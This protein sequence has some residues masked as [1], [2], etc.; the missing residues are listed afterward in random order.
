M[1][2]K[3]AFLLCLFSATCLYARDFV[4]LFSRADWDSVST[5]NKIKVRDE[6]KKCTT[7][8]IPIRL[9][10]TL[11]EAGT[12]NEWGFALC[13]N[14]AWVLNMKEKLTQAKIDK[15]KNWTNK[16]ESFVGWTTNFPALLVSKGLEYKPTEDEMP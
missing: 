3:L 7:A 15:I 2:L 16:H 4:F 6:L 14:G 1:K 12:T 13:S 8:P 10:W 5:A 9:V 11:Q